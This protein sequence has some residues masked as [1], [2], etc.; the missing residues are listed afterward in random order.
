MIDDL[1]DSTGESAAR[2][3]KAL[4][5][6]EA[7]ISAL[8][9]QIKDSKAKLKALTDELEHKLQLKRL[10]GED[11][12]VESKLL[13]SQVETQARSPRMKNK[14]EDKKKIAALQKDK[15]ALET[16]MAKTDALLAS[17]GGKLTE[18]DA[19]TL[20]LRKLYDL[21]NQEL[22]RYLHAQTRVLIRG[23]EILWDKYALS[24]RKLELQ[25][26]ETLEALDEYLSRLG[27]MGMT[28]LDGWKSKPLSEL[29]S[30]FILDFRGRTPKKL[31]M[32]W[33]NGDIPALSANNVEMG[34]I[35]FSKE[36]YL[37][38][39]ALYRKWMTRGDAQKRET[40]FLQPRLR[41]GNVAQIPDD[42]RYI[43]SQGTILLRANDAEVSS[44]YLKHYS[45][46]RIAAV[47][48]SCA[49]S[50]REPRVT[51]YTAS[52]NLEKLPVSFPI[53]QFEQAKIAEILSTKRTKRSKRRRH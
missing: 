24:S 11:F 50:P 49:N 12:K 46:Q 20:I 38:S 8:E 6:Q 45:R 3:L 51:G 36:C 2:E 44:D 19:K 48:T 7:A 1:E 23:V 26:T 32:E 22:N 16:R 25:R 13:F 14:K 53:S 9:K 15:A 47:R 30:L 33:G 35:D 37:G 10:G 39:D 18:T 40:S 41:L 29:L 52:K 43:L 34:K 27:Y 21:A 4:Q 5:A 17:I 42:E 28:A 31:G